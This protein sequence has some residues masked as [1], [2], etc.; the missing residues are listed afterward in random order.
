MPLLLLLPAL[1]YAY[2]EPASS[3]LPSHEERLVHVLTNQ[4]R[5]APHDWPGWDTS[6]A[7]GDPRPPLVHE[8]GLEQAAR[9]HA[10]DMAAHDFF[11][12]DSSDGTSFA[13]RI[14]H[15]FPGNA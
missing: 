9:F 4:V 2:G 11:S 3:D 6:L 14:T 12:H 15:Y 8:K 10:D 5:Q 7:S 1:I 13:V